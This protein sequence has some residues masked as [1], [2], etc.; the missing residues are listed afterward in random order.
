MGS[1]E[2]L[3]SIY[4]VLRLVVPGSEYVLCKHYLSTSL[5]SSS[6]YQ[7]QEIPTGKINMKFHL[8]TKSFHLA[9]LIKHDYGPDTLPSS[10]LGAE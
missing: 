4:K 5:S 10:Y 9:S 7:M 3:I 6:F 1:H 2:K 8:D